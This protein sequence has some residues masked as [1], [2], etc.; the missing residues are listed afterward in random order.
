MKFLELNVLVCGENIESYVRDTE[1][2]D[3]CDTTTE[4][5]RVC[6]VFG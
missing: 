3:V 5:V 4:D 2:D 6:I 1:S